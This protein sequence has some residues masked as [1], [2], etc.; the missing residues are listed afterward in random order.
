VTDQPTDRSKT[1][2]RKE[3][4]AIED[5]PSPSEVAE[6]YWWRWLA[7]ELLAFLEQLEPLPTLPED[8]RER[9]SSLQQRIKNGQ[10]GQ[11]KD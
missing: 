2:T 4:A 8:L 11:R 1:P 9:A 6:L 10:T 3:L 7:P 5:V